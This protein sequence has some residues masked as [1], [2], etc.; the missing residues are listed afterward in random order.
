MI[1]DGL[2]KSRW[3]C[4]KLLNG[5][6]FPEFPFRDGT[7]IGVVFNRDMHGIAGVPADVFQSVLDAMAEFGEHLLTFVPAVDSLGG[8]DDAFPVTDLAN[9]QQYLCFL[10]R[11]DFCPEYYL[12]SSRG[13]VLFWFDAD[14]VVVGGRAEVIRCAV[15]HLG[16][17]DGVLLRST[18]DFGVSLGDAQSDVATYIGN[19]AHL[20]KC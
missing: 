1:H 17:M 2:R 9:W 19:L 7:W 6:P 3:T 16:G 14:A 4:E 20:P 15:A 8:S 10:K 13:T 5:S 12:V 11:I 18:S